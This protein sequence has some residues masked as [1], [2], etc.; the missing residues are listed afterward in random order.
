MNKPLRAPRVSVST[1]VALRPESDGCLT[2][3]AVRRARW[4]VQRNGRV[5]VSIYGLREFQGEAAALI[6]RIV[7]DAQAADVF[8]QASASGTVAARLREYVQ[9]SA[10]EYAQAVAR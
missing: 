8:I 3:E 5:V 10:T 9:N 1:Y 4:N 7:T 6:G 2:V